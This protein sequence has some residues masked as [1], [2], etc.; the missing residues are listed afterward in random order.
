MPAAAG[1]M[2]GTRTEGSLPAL[3]CTHLLVG[4]MS[5]DVL[6]QEISQ[7][8]TARP[9]L[10]S[11]SPHLGCFL[12]SSLST[13]LASVLVCW[14]LRNVVGTPPL[15]S[16]HSAMT[17]KYQGAQFSQEWQEGNQTAPCDA[18]R[19]TLVQG[20]AG[21]HV[22][23]M[24]AARGSAAVSHKS[25][26]QHHISYIA[27]VKATGCARAPRAAALWVLGQAAL[28]AAA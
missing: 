21:L 20:A 7:S 17:C 3:Q 24:H 8:I 18:I 5:R 14:E 19:Q 25:P 23:S 2:R 16:W 22:C 28:T 13:L 12:N 1:H 10:A 26:H 9:L 4:T 27:R 15:G 6:R 11:C